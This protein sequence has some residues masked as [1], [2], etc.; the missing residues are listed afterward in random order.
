L[1]RRSQLGLKLAWN[2]WYGWW[3]WC[4]HLLLLLPV[5]TP[6]T[7]YV[8]S[9][10]TLQEPTTSAREPSLLRRLEASGLL[11]LEPGGLR[12]KPSAGTLLLGVEPGLLRVEAAL[13]LLLE[14]L[15]LLLELLRV[16]SREPR[17][18]RVLV[19]SWLAPS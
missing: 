9:R 16:S 4:S 13:W 10:L 14:L 2:G 8:T 6:T 19:S 12:S 17:L 7:T 15:R 18:L 5:P 11:R 1:L 3:R